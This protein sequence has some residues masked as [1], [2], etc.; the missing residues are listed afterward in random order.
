M[1]E[2]FRKGDKVICFSN[3]F[4]VLQNLSDKIESDIVMAATRPKVNDKLTVDEVYG[5]FINFT[6]HN[7]VSARQ[8]FHQS[9]FM[10]VNERR[11][12]IFFGSSLISYSHPPT[13]IPN[14]PNTGVEVDPNRIIREGCTSFCTK[15]NSSMVKESYF[16]RLKCINPEC[17]NK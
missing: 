15:C 9:R 2:K 5:E 8:W 14:D 12:D 13:R 3:N 1:N 6:K 11:K 16:S 17:D 7:T 4:S 10:F